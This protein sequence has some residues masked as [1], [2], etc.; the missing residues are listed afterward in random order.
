MNIKKSMGGEVI[1]SGGFGCIFSP[2]LKCQNRV[3]ENKIGITKL[4]KKS[5]A[6][7]EYD[8]I[9]KYRPILKKIKNYEKYFLMGRISLCIPSKLSDEDLKHYER[10]CFALNK[11]IKKEEVNNSLNKLMGINIPYGGIEVGTYIED[12]YKIVELNRKLIQLLKN[13]IIPMN[14]RNLFHCDLKSSNILVIEEKNVLLTRIIDWGLSTIYNKNDEIPEILVGRPFQYNMP[15]SIILFNSLFKKEYEKFLNNNEEFNYYN[16][17]KFI[18]NY[19]IIFVNKYGQGHLKTINSI[20]KELFEDDFSENI[21]DEFKNNIII[22]DYTFYFIFD[23]LTQILLKY[24]DTKNKQFQEVKYFNEVFVR[25]VDIW[26]FASVYLSFLE[27]LH[28][29][30]DKL[31]ADQE[32]IIHNIKS[33]YYILLDNSV[34]P[35]DTVALIDK[36]ELLNSSLLFLKNE[37]KE[38]REKNEKKETKKLIKK[39]ETRKMKKIIKN[40][41]KTIKNLHK[42]NKWI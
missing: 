40:K 22:F 36:L 24:T 42:N 13:G 15:F 33:I 14:N 29:N 25:N 26:G 32:M 21:D 27:Y 19:I 8:E 16:V 31:N 12:N 17:R 39:R 28:N 37:N 2:E 9:N 11:T 1:N 20:I 38:K 5:Y 6:K 4:M 23:Y 18:I 41:L 3:V 35:I 30:Y 10:K 34:K 7:S